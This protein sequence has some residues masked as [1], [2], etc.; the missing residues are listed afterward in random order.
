MS[1]F[2][3]GY[4][5]THDFA[6]KAFFMG[7]YDTLESAEKGYNACKNEENLQIIRVQVVK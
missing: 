6:Y 1:K 5:I 2:T 4:Y 7:P 3:N